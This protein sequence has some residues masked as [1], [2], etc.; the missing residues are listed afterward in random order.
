MSKEKAT[1]AHLR[2]AASAA[3]K[4]E[5]N[6]WA[7]HEANSTDMS[8]ER[9]RAT[10]G[11]MVAAT[12]GGA[13]FIALFFDW[14]AGADQAGFAVGVSAW[15]ALGGVDVV[16]AVLASVPVVEAVLR[17]TLSPRPEP[18]VPR[19]SVVAGSGMAALIFAVFRLVD[20]PERAGVAAITGHRVGSLLA[21]IAATGVVLGAAAAR[22]ERQA[23]SQW[24]KG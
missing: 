7:R 24:R 1:A 8:V 17:L 11:E 2:L 21:V 20:L 9:K 23:Q 16:L 12:S 13:L 18:R 5:L 4:I 14:Y 19:A 3:V 22:G 10:F 6:P 15:Q